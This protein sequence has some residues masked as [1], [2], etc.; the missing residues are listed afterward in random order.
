MS[1]T[2]INIRVG[3]MKT[4]VKT[5]TSPLFLLKISLHFVLFCF[6]LKPSKQEEK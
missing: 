5:D 3:H 1:G 2:V 4:Q 6:V